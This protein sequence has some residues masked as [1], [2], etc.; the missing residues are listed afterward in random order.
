MDIPVI[1]VPFAPGPVKKRMSKG[2]RYPFRV[3]YVD[4]FGYDVRHDSYSDIDVA[5]KKAEALC[6]EGRPGVRILDLRGLPRIEY[7]GD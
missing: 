1:K 2:L 4:G 6:S 7:E 5:V 3:F